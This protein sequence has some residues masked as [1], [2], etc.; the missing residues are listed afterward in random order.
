MY[1]YNSST[2]THIL[3]Q[4]DTCMSMLKSAGTCCSFVIHSPVLKANLKTLLNLWEKLYA[5]KKN[6]IWQKIIWRPT[7]LNCLNLL[8]SQ[9]T[10]IQLKYKLW[11]TLISCVLL[12][13][14][15]VGSSS[16]I[17]LNLMEDI[18]RYESYMWI[19]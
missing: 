15:F 10:N 3:V 11:Y 6:F 1:T 7:S 16:Q 19:K 9:C 12:I 18:R 4:N 14:T 17:V 13:G 2:K 5:R 8:L